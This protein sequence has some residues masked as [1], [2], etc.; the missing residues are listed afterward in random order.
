MRSRGPGGAT[1]RPAAPPNPD[2][3]RDLGPRARPERGATQRFNQAGSWL[4][5]VCL[6]AAFFV[7][8]FEV[9]SPAIFELGQWV[10]GESPT[11]QS[12]PPG[13]PR[14]LRARGPN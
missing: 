1:R 6:S 4:E 3:P 9:F 10:G 11:Y 12:R 2:Q 8:E 14:G 7:H 5:D 13:S